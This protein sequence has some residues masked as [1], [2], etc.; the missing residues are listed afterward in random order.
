MTP[1]RLSG[2]DA[3]FLYMET[4]TLHMHVAITAVFDPS[5]VPGGYSFR[6]VRQLIGD[7]IPLAPVFQR[8]LVEVPMRLG[9]PVWVDDP[10]F[11]IDNHHDIVNRMRPPGTGFIVRTVAENVSEEKLAADIR[12]L[13]QVWNEVGK[14]K[15]KKP[16][17][18]LLHP[19]LDMVLRATR[20]LF[21]HEVGKL[22]IDDR[23]EYERVLTFVEAQEPALKEH[24]ELYVGEEPVFDAYGIEQEIKRA[25]NRKVWL[26]S[27]GY[28]IIDQAEALVAI[29][30]NSGRY[31]GKKNLEETI[32]RINVEAAKEIVYQLRLRNNGGIIIIDF[33][34]MD[35][36]QNRDKVFKAMQEALGRD[37][38][39]TNVLK[40]SELGLIEMTRK[41]VRESL[42][43]TLNEPCSYCDGKG[44]IRSKV[45]VAY[46]IFRELRRE[47]PNFTEPLL[48]INCHPEVAKLIQT[49]E[50]DELR[51]LMDRVNKSIQVKPQPTYHQEQFD[52]HGK[53]VQAQKG[54]AAASGASP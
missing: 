8:R 48:I 20:D 34:D 52:I 38:A 47:A 42:G 26:K 27:G 23:D 19:D 25:L 17:P 54:G 46:D 31:V 24:V 2:L 22:V 37:R 30:V 35:K 51:Q 44:F 21:T 12:F 53:Q 29:D 50:R 41:R 13:I 3:S 28:I 36:P 40:I 1:E 4:P 18:A 16:A 7:R 33:I 9:F 49:E 10:E 45:T 39:K 5:T 43:R 15:D 14:E 6:R 32:T 11:D